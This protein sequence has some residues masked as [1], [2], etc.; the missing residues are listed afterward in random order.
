MHKR[1]TAMLMINCKRPTQSTVLLSV[2]MIIVAVESFKFRFLHL[3][4][5][6]VSVRARRLFAK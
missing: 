4:A 6:A 2:S 1:S 3:R 5:C